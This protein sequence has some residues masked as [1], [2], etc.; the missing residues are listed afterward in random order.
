MIPTLNITSYVF[1]SIS[2]SKIND[3]CTSSDS[4]SDFV[5]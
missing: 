4:N 3:S 1:L 2:A 5:I